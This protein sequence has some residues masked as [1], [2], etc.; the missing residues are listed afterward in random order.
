[1]AYDG[2]MQLLKH[3]HINFF[4]A[5]MGRDG[6]GYAALKITEAMAALG[7]P[8]TRQDIRSDEGRYSP[9]DGRLLESKYPAVAMT[10]PDWLPAIK[11]PRLAA[12][13]MFEA[14]GLPEGWV[15]AMNDHAEFVTVPCSWC[16]EVF[17][18]NGVIKPIHVITWGV[19]DYHLV[20]RKPA[21]DRP[22]TFLWSGNPDLRKGWDVAYKAF[23]MAFGGKDQRVRLRLHFRY[24]LMGGVTF[25]DRNVEV[26]TGRFFR[27]EL[28]A[29]LQTADCFVFPTRGEGWGMPPREAALT[30]L[31]VITTNYGGTAVGI[32]NWAFP[33]GIDGMSSADYGFWEAG[34]I[35]QWAEP[36]VVE[37]AALMRWCF[38]N[39]ELAADAGRQASHWLKRNA[40]W[41]Q[42]ARQFW[43][44]LDGYGW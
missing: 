24:P 25:A 8:V 11:A 17:E 35:G 26:V 15:Q 39:Q 43:E 41:E 33:I 16:K 30:G 5:F 2:H 6:Y 1:M 42:T 40:T 34:T 13:T 29:M 23:I 20:H 18:A 38:E 9:D 3:D 36:S 4:S 21:V 12:H 22:Y 19:S 7:L 10:V 14:T 31:P 27:P 32:D 37:A 28:Q 44:V